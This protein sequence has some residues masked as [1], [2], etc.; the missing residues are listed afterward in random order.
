LC[1]K[2]VSDEVS[3]TRIPVQWVAQAAASVYDL[4]R[5][6]F[7]AGR[8]LPQSLANREIYVSENNRGLEDQDFMKILGLA[9]RN[10]C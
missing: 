9:N 6:N 10:R 2:I 8:W 3:K 7:N 5:R 4:G 1:S